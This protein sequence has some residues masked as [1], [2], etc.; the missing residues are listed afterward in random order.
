MFFADLKEMIG[1]IGSKLF[2]KTF[3]QVSGWDA[4]FLKF[5]QFTIDQI[6]AIVEENFDLASYVN[7]REL[8]LET[9]NDV[10]LL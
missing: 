2:Y 7:I 5:V 8:L 1:G 3:K 4:N 9:L 6:G 10:R